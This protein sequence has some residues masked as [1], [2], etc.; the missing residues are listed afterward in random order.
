MPATCPFLFVHTGDTYPEYV[1]HAIRQARKWNPSSNIYFIAEACYQPKTYEYP[2]TFVSLEAIESFMKKKYEKNNSTREKLVI[3]ED[4]MNINGYYEC[5]YLE[6][7]SM[8]YFDI[9]YMLPTLREEYAGIA[10]P[11]VGNGSVSFGMLYVANR[12]TLSNLN[13]FL[14]NRSRTGL[15]EMKLGFRFILENRVEADFLP[16]VSNEC[17]VRDEDYSYATAHGSAFRGVFDAASYGQYLGGSEKLQIGFL[18]K[19]SAFPADQFEYKPVKFDDGLLFWSAHRHGNSW[20][21]YILQVQSKYLE[22]FA[23]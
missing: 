6:N 1:V 12:N 15:D 2:C 22:M 10:V 19:N 23:S 16:V 21:L 8:I 5:I 17:D 4:F 13:E 11:Y 3:L 20:P 14:F 9:E 7:H 18:D